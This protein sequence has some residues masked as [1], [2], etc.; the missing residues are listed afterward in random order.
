MIKFFRK[1]RQNLL[2]EGK[3]G[4]YFKYALG[5]IILVVIGILIALQINNLNE[6]RKNK[7]QE[8]VLLKGLSSDLEL[9]IKQLEN[10]QITTNQRLEKIKETLALFKTSEQVNSAKFGPRFLDFIFD[11]YFTCNSGVFDEAVSSGKM[12][13]VAHEKLS[14]DIFNYYRL[15]KN[16]AIDETT[17]QNTDL[18]IAPAFQEIFTVN[19]AFEM[20]GFDV[21]EIANLED[22]NI[23]KLKLN[24]DFWT[25][26][27][28]K[29][30]HSFEQINSWNLTEKRA[31][32]L[33]EQIDI[34]IQSLLYD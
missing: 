2:S 27:L 5:E 20:Y 7:E 32:K 33:K 30:G 14:K 29:I 6:N 1:I 18:I 19:Q 31:S 12:S 8:I 26:T 13:L 16:N 17:R 4:K 25:M 21:S 10:T 23:E 9:D 15:A 34:E 24:K 11:N 3:T 28:A 22:I